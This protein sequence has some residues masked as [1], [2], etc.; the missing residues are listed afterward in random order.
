MTVDPGIKKVTITKSSLPPVNGINQSYILRYRIVS[1]DKNRYSHWSPQYVVP[2][3]PIEEINFSLKIDQS[4]N[5]LTLIWE[6]VADVTTFDVYTRI[7]SGAWNYSSTVST[8]TYSSLI[9]PA[10]N[11]IEIA[12][13]IPTYPKTRSA[14]ATLFVTPQTNI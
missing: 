2:A 9:N 8:T 3:Q 5:T 6:P 14:G 7:D 11:H 4:S 12:V 10:F 13:Q 1:E